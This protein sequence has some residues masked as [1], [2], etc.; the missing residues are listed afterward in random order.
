MTQ[1]TLTAAKLRK[2]TRR[3]P[4]AQP[5]P[6]AASS[7]ADQTPPPTGAPAGKLGRV[8]SLLRRPAGANITELMDATGWQAHSVRGAI[9]GAIKKKLGLQVLSTK[10]EA[11]RV[12]R[13]EAADDAA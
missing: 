7:A 4:K 9:A 3:G 5:L 13:I 10:S 2:T 1:K 11:G 6:A 12:Y 8:I